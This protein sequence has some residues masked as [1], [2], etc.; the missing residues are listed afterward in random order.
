MSMNTVS[1]R[2]GR[3]VRRLLVATSI[4]AAV[5]A[6]G[7]VVPAGAGSSD[8]P[9]LR[10]LCN[11]LAK[12]P[13]QG[14][15]EQ[16]TDPPTGARI[17]PGQ[18][19]TV[20]L[21]WDRRDFAGSD[22]Q[23]AGHCIVTLDGRPRLELSALE[24]PSANDGEYRGSF[25]MPVDLAPGDCLC[26]LGVASGDAPEGGPLRVGGNSCLTVTD[27]AP[28]TTPVTSPPATPATTS[29]PARPPA[30]VLPAT[31]TAQPSE[32]GVSSSTQSTP[33]PLRELPRTGPFDVRLVLALGGLALVLGGGAVT[34]RR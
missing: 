34:T 4:T 11:E 17:R 30:T 2:T 1:G 29:P 15:A 18:K 24:A 16:I 14:G 12:D 28:P 3:R 26:V 21:R 8:D 27:P 9:G 32:P 20:T 5:A 13:P 7:G 23:Q 19:V 33:Q 31:E 25:V 22:L 10:A 6:A